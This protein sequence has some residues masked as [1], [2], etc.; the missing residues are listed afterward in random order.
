MN[1]VILSNT[2]FR[3]HRRLHSVHPLLVKRLH[4]PQLLVRVKRETT[5][6]GRRGE[7]GRGGG[8]VVDKSSALL[9]LPMA[10]RLHSGGMPVALA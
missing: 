2:A 3:L 5:S 9:S 4:S 1:I 10:N 8:V 7:G 6:K